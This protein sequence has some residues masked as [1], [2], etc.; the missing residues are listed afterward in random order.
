M[1]AAETVMEA[2]TIPSKSVDTISIMPDTMAVSQSVTAT[3]CSS[4]T[5]P[6]TS[7]VNTLLVRKIKFQ[8]TSNDA[9]LQG[10]TTE[11]LPSSTAIQLEDNLHV[12][13]PQ[14][15]KVDFLN[16]NDSRNYKISKRQGR[17]SKKTPA[18]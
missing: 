2:T 4:P 8:S 12:K 3:T 14:N 9:N 15:P 5:R 11:Q 7:S 16:L 17:A 1:Y 13:K 10:L 18:K 6:V